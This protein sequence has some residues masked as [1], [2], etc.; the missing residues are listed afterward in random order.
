MEPRMARWHH[1]R[2]DTSDR[3][4]E[5]EFEESAP[6][7]APFSAKAKSPGRKVLENG[8]DDTDLLSS[9]MCKAAR[10]P[11]D[12]AL[13]RYFSSPEE[14]PP[15]SMALNRRSFVQKLRPR[16]RFNRVH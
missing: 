10:T 5:K 8:A 4:S 13:L 3:S 12:I 15:V 2:F 1:P 6:T 16:K 11:L 14:R 9:S 7:M